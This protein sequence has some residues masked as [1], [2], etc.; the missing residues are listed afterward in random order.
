MGLPGEN[1]MMG[2]PPN[3]GPLRPVDVPVAE[4]VPDADV[5]LV[6]L[7][8]AVEPA[9]GALGSV[10]PPAALGLLGSV[11]P[12]LPRVPEALMGV[13]PE[14]GHPAIGLEEPNVEDEPNEEEEPKEDDE[15]KEEDGEEPKL[16]DEL[17]G[18]MELGRA[19]PHRPPPPIPAPPNGT[20]KNPIAVGALFWP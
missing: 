14:G 17:L 11:V 4:V 10:L 1:P 2:P 9:F 13:D 6:P 3:C 20:P 8:S 16:L 5:P 7:A 15:P 18:G 12:E 19:L